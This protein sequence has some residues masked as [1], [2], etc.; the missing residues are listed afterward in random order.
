MRY[1]TA[2]EIMNENF[3]GYEELG[4]ISDKLNLLIDTNFTTS[5][6]NIPFE[7]SYLRSISNTHFLILFIPK[8]KNNQL[9]TL[10]GLRSLFGFNPEVS[11][12]CFYNQDWY[13]NESFA[14][15]SFNA[16]HWFCIRKEILIETRGQIIY[17]DSDL[18]LALVCTYAFFAV[19]FL[20]KKYLWENDYVWCKDLDENGDRIYVGRYFDPKGISKNGF[21]IHR[22]L[23]I[24]KMFGSLS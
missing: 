23:S 17:D 13:L 19:Y 9:I 21:S 7:E 16:E 3:I 1:D 11:E 18:P 24:N 5:S 6:V 4:T 10:N 12:P 8:D 15:N 22:H 20:T 14:N 2:K